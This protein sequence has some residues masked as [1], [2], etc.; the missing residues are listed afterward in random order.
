M[1]SLIWTNFHVPWGKNCPLFEFSE[2]KNISDES[3]MKSLLC[4]RCQWR[5]KTLSRHRFNCNVLRFSQ[6]G[7]KAITFGYI[8]KR[9]IQGNWL[10]NQKIFQ[11]WTVAVFFGEFFIASGAQ[12][13]LFFTNW[14]AETILKL[15]VLKSSSS[16]NPI[17]SIIR[18]FFI[19]PC[20]FEL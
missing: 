2:P 6:Y 15:N 19:S 3:Q 16:H 14:E 13:S 1:I 20:E 9:E 11:Y 18:S 8:F 12:Y 17:I 10:I 7:S 5:K 4:S